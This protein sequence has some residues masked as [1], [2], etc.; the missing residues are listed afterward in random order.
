VFSEVVASMV[1][2][3][4][5]VPRGEEQIREYKQEESR[6]WRQDAVKRV[7]EDSAC[8]I[9]TTPGTTKRKNEEFEDD[10]S[11]D[12][13]GR[14]ATT[15]TS[16]KKS[17]VSSQF[18]I[19]NQ[20]LNS[21]SDKGLE[22]TSEEQTLSG[23]EREKDSFERPEVV[24]DDS[25]SS[26][27]EFQ[28]M[29]ENVLFEQSSGACSSVNDDH[30]SGTESLCSKFCHNSCHTILQSWSDEDVRK[31]KGMFKSDKIVETKTKLLD[32][33]KHQSLVGLPVSSVIVKGQEFCSKFFAFITGCSEYIVKTVVENFH[34]G[35][36]LF[37]HGNKG[38]LKLETPAAVKAICWIKAFSEAYGQ[39][40]PED[41]LT[42]LSYWLN[43]QSLFHMY[44]DETNGP[45]VK[46]SSFYE[47][48]KSKFG[49][50]RVDQ[51][52]PWVRISKF[53]THSV[54][55]TCVLLN[56]NIKQCK[57]EIE[58]E[59]AKSLKNNHRMNFGL[60]RRK[61]EEVKQSAL[62]FPS[63]HLFLQIDGMDNSKSY[64]PR[65]LEKS[66]DQAQKERLPTKISGCLMY[67]GWYENNRKV[68]FYLNHDIFENGSNLIVTLVYL[69]LEEFVKDW[70]KLPRKL[71]LN[72][73]NCWK[74]NKNR[75]LFSFLAS[76]L[77][78]SIFEEI[79]CDYLMVGHTGNEVDQL[80][81][82]LCPQFKANITTIEILKEKITSAPIT[83][84]PI[85]KS[86][87]FI[88]DWKLFV[89]DK[90]TNPP[91]KFHSKYNSFLLTVDM[92]QE[93]RSVKLF[94]KKLPQDSEL[95]PRPGIR[96]IQDGVD[97]DQVVGPADYRVEKLEFD[98]IMQGVHMFVSKIPLQERRTILSSWDRLRDNLESL[99]R[100]SESFPKMRLVD[101]PKQQQESLQV[102][103]YLVEHEDEGNELTGDKFPEVITEGDFDSDIC[104]GMDVCT[105]TEDKQGRPW[106]GRIMQLLE[107]GKF[108]LQWYVRKTIKSKTFHAL[109][110][111]DGGPSVTELDNETVICWQMSENRTKNSFDLS[112]FWLQHLVEEYKTLDG[113]GE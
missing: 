50:S 92:C 25:T 39:Y 45:H 91:L 95:V 49:P 53:S 78:L 67:N 21:D 41:N 99:P 26:Y 97:F 111:E 58:L 55:S 65:Y 103:D 81:S 28:Y 13:S 110:N 43:K 101:L 83:P 5:L 24:E 10:E 66:K 2:G 88:Y 27:G 44:L 16:S 72:L 12:R 76:L 29:V 68:M 109:T 84:K 79:T 7:S 4:G 63:D 108:I 64:L 30:G 40:S 104:I 36:E 42:V 98:K 52:L 75:F 22:I 9:S 62:S 33:L 105:Y 3:R 86:L 94:A 37:E 80:F 96:V 107:N 74:E 93:K 77:Q 15:P 20:L 48:F 31:L 38:C 57:T 70:S 56:Q 71:H 23:M 47:L 17:N 89:G 60:A 82:C 85:C 87:D 69:L 1:V 102:P 54:C 18:R 34:A 8:N 61:I 73:D 11:P 112:N 59:Q 6:M 35:I 32:H 90:L 14:D 51:T 113:A 106:V 100:R 46:Q 19:E